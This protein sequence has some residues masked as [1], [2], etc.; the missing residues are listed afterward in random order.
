MGLKRHHISEGEVLA[1]EVAA[2]AVGTEELKDEAVSGAKTS[3]A[4]F[5]QF[6]AASGPAADV[7]IAAG[8]TGDVDISVSFP[9]TF[10]ATPTGFVASY[11]ALPAGL[12][13]IGVQ[14]FGETTT[15][16]TIRITCNNPTAAAITVTAG[17]IT[18]KWIATVIT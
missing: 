3:R 2:A 17:S 8:A 12:E 6:G 9:T 4:K 14:T 11:T 18:A 1:G 13:V 16:M 7:S 5:I 10:A 15:G